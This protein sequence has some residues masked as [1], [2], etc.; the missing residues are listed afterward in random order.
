[1]SLGNACTHGTIITIKVMNISI[2]S[3]NFLCPFAFWVFFSWTISWD[4]PE[5]HWVGYSLC[6][7]LITS[8][9]YR[10]SCTVPASFWFATTPLSISKA[11]KNKAPPSGGS[12]ETLLGS[13][14]DST[15]PISNDRNAKENSSTITFWVGKTLSH[16]SLCAVL[17]SLCLFTKLLHSIQCFPNWVLCQQL[18]AAARAAAAST[19]LSLVAV[20]LSSPENLSSRHTEKERQRAA[21]ILH[22]IFLKVLS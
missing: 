9:V 18:S 7:S 17:P 15:P 5:G 10:G 4:H 16:S 11:E 1:M 22:K 21:S 6:R 3:K 8:F 20:I 12:S 2:T 13:L 19:S 14:V